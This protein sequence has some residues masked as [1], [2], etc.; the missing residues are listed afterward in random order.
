MQAAVVMKKCQNWIS[1]PLDKSQQQNPVHLAT[2]I[3]A[4]RLD[5]MLKRKEVERAFLG[6]IRLVK[7]DSEGMEAPEEST[8]IQKPKWDQAL[9]PQIRA[10]IEEFDDVFP[11]DL[12]LGL[13]PLRQG[14]E[15]KIDLEDDVAPVHRP[16]YKMSPLELD[17]AKKQVESMLEHGFVKPSDSPYGAPVL[18]IPKKDGSLWFCI[19]Y[20]WLNKKTVK[21]RYPLPLP[22][23]LFDRLGSARVFSKIDLQSGYW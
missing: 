1:L 12:P 13:P 6:I 18:F 9:P 4:T 21:N 23:E 10:V 8:T 7:E 14:H 20:R 19:D 22:E 17:E 11:Q 5:K 16:L 3:S 15:F 2:K